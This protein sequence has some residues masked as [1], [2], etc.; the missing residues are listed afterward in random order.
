M[1][2]PI[3]TPNPL[4]PAWNTYIDGQSFNVTG[5][6][7]SPVTLDFP[8]INGFIYGN[9]ANAAVLAFNIGFSGMLMIVLLVLSNAK[10]ARQ[11]IFVLNFITLVVFCV[12]S[13]ISL[14]LDCDVAWYGVP[15]SFIGAIAQYPFPPIAARTVFTGITAILV[16]ALIFIS[17]ILQTR[18]VFAAEPKTQMIVTV[19]LS[20]LAI[21]IEGLW[22][23]F[24]VMIQMVT[25]EIA[26]NGTPITVASW[27]Y[28]TVQY[29]FISFVGI[30]CL[31]FLYKLFFIVR[32]RRRMGFRSFGP[33]QILFIM[34]S[35]CLVIPR[36]LRSLVI[37]NC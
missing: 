13:I 14:D 11:P 26:D 24:Q 21:V 29:L 35:Q 3:P 19:G 8:D 33:M 28:Y 17:L 4:S 2:T 20:I 7:G 25:F 32:R 22:F 5:L 1:S 18:V 36:T 27:L 34:V 9:I 16:N 6:D 31:I 37:A 30:C 12:R 23:T 10:K 15:Q